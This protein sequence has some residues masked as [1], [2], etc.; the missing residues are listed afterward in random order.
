VVVGD[1]KA[2]VEDSNGNMETG[3]ALE[4]VAS[5]PSKELQKSTPSSSRGPPVSVILKWMGKEFPIDDIGGVKTVRELKS[6]FRERTGVLE[7]RQKLLNVT[8]MGEFLVYISILA[9]LLH[10]GAIMNE[11]GIAYWSFYR[12]NCW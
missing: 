5:I 3:A 11:E 7:D 1:A 9:T 2:A 6:L 4:D 12:K 8:F 10:H